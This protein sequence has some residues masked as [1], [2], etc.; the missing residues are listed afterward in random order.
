MKHTGLG[1][2]RDE[3]NKALAGEFAERNP[4]R[5]LTKVSETTRDEEAIIMLDYY[6]NVWLAW[7]PVWNGQVT[8]Y[9]P[10]GRKFKR[11]V[12]SRDVA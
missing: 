9:N 2:T 11:K 7:L 1:L 10:S 8:N 3:R 4:G 6:A 5:G 12:K